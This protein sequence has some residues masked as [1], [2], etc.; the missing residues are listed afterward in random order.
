[1]HF[2]TQRDPDYFCTLIE[3][4]R[5]SIPAGAH[6]LSRA[7]MSD[8]PRAGAALPSINSAR[9]GGEGCAGDPFPTNEV[10]A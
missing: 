8:R 9:A 6:P 3:F 2:V 7:P 4:E 1:M 5:D 10:A